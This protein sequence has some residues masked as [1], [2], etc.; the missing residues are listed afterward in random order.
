MTA[1]SKEKIELCLQ[2]GAE[3]GVNYRQEEFQVARDTGQGGEEYM[4]AT[5]TETVLYT[6]QSMDYGGPFLY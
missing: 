1:G 3:R 2:L 4:D 6:F 5:H